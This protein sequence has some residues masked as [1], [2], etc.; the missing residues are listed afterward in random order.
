MSKVTKNI[1]SFKL[2]IFKIIY[3]KIIWFRRCPFYK[4]V[5]VDY[6]TIYFWIIWNCV[7]ELSKTWIK[8]RS[9][10]KIKFDFIIYLMLSFKY[11]ENHTLQFIHFL[12]LYA[13]RQVHFQ[14]IFKQNN[15]IYL[16]MDR[17][18]IKINIHAKTPILY[19]GKSF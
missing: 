1:D 7:L 15:S 2:I 19:W 12:L 3:V 6:L 10:I 11:K 14:L 16:W 4:K 8:R 9:I 17:R 18:V 13:P 5:E